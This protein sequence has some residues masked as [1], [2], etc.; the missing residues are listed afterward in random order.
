MLNI[1]RVI[2]IS[3]FSRAST[4]VRSKP[5]ASRL[6]SIA[7]FGL[8]SLTTLSAAA[9][10]TTS[11][12]KL[13]DSIA[14][15]SQRYALSDTHTKLVS[16]NGSGYDRLTGVRN[17]RRVLNGLVYRGGA[18]NSFRTP[19]R[20]NE[21]PL[22]PEAVENLCKEGFSTSIYLY[23]QNYETSEHVK[24]CTSIGG[25]SN[26]FSYLQSSVTSSDDAAR[27]HA[28]ENILS[29][30]YDHIKGN[31]HRPIYLHCWNGWHASGFASAI[32]LRQFCGISGNDAVKYWDR[33]TDGVS[34]PSRGKIHSWIRNFSP[35]AKYSIS[36]DAQALLC[37]NQ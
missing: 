7:I 12:A 21:N 2:D 1:N 17:F 32:V 15:Y 25:G 23:K 10:E 24:D 18:N 31:D 34:V 11:L 3:H 4:Y 22:P 27:S 8:V 29:I 30:I 37:A 6:P 28:L 35:D 19:K 13:E 33:N 26:N 14:F 36:S 9:D 5:R 20:D 16:N